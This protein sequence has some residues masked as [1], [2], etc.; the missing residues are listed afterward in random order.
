M[1]LIARERL[2]ALASVVDAAH[3]DLV[4]RD[5]ATRMWAGDHTLWQDDPTEVADRLGWLHVPGE[6]RGAD[7]DIDHG[8]RVALLGMGGSSLFPEVLARTFPSSTELHVLDTTDPAAIARVPI[9]GTTFIAA[10]KSGGTIE[11]ISQLAHFWDATSGDASRFVVIT[12]PGTSLAD[13]AH[14]RGF[15]RVFENR[16]DIGGRYSALSCFGLV[17]AQA[18]GVD[19]EGTLLRP[20]MEVDDADGVRLGAIVGAA[21]KAG[22]DKL[23]LLLPDEIA[24]FGLWVEQL[25]AESTGK[26]GVGIVPIVGEPLGAPDSYGDDRLFVAHVDTPGLDDLAAAG[27]PVVEVRGHLGAR[28]MLWEQA[29]ALSGVVLGINPFDQ[30]DVQSA[31]DA[32]ARVLRDGLPPI[33]TVAPRD[34]LSSASPG[35][36]LALLAFVDPGDVELGE[37]LQRVRRALRDRLRIATT[38]GVGPRFLHSTGQLHKGGPATGIFLQVL[39]ADETDLDIPERPYTFS[40]LKQAQAA[41]DLL[42]LQARGLRAGRVTLDALMEEVEG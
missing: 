17:P 22:R 16:P 40:T 15:Q 23:T 25:V 19:V 24:T 21:A 27:H 41:G 12:D 26:H 5:A 4:E 42:A 3:A 33:A 7:L 31:K 20:A 13:L 34:L 18:L 9:D 10:S 29:I 32:T 14:E 36:Y 1:S 28:V 8:G 6:M 39:G 37:Q 11:T 30:P 38:V 35:D 2:G